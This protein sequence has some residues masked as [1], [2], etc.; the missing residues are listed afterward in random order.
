VPVPTDGAVFALPLIPYLLSEAVRRK[1]TL[2]MTELK[3]A[4]DFITNPALMAEAANAADKAAVQRW[5]AKW[6]PPA[7]PEWFIPAMRRLAGATV[8]AATDED[9]PPIVLTGALSV[10]NSSLLME[11]IQLAIKSLSSAPPI[12]SAERIA[13]IHERRTLF[14]AA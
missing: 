6:Q 1:Q 4:F 9:D 11:G 7:G 12:P 5:A 13:L 8:K 3:Q 2:R 10:P 14:A